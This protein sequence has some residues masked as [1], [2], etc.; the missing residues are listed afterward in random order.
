MKYGIIWHTA[1]MSMSIPTAV[2]QQEAGKLQFSRDGQLHSAREHQSSLIRIQYG[3][4]EF[5]ILASTG[6]L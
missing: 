1:R 2:R 4:Q 6:A 3:H 5:M